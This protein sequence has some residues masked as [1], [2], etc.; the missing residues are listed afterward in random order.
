MEIVKLWCP[1]EVKHVL[2]SEKEKKKKI[3]VTYWTIGSVG[4]KRSIIGFDPNALSFDVQVMYH[5]ASYFCST[6]G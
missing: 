2:F 5:N 6:T 3:L 4:R 1:N